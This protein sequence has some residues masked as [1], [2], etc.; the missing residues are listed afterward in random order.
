MTRSGENDKMKRQQGKK[1]Q[2]RQCDKQ[3]C[4]LYKVESGTGK[5]EV[6][7]KQEEGG[8]RKE[9]KMRGKC[10]IYTKKEEKRNIRA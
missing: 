3:Y 7:K 5:V 1:K 2:S 10:G 9:V 4:I 8:G 6:E